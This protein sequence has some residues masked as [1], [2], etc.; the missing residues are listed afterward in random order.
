MNE[1]LTS[2]QLFEL[3]DG[4]S[5][6]NLHREFEAHLA[7]C[8][9]CREALALHARIDAAARALPHASTSATFTARTMNRLPL[10]APM[11]RRALLYRR[12]AQCAAFLA[13]A[14][15]YIWLFVA[16]DVDARGDA[17]SSSAPISTL[18]NNLL[19]GGKQLMTT[20]GGITWLHLL[21]GIAL[22]ALLASLDKAFLS[23]PHHS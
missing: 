21:T 18:G 3:M 22:I 17:A 13:V 20:L 1:H 10:D 14:A 16:G 8:E 15:L 11:N 6:E 7:A 12:L 23:K 4:G 9:Q 2:E 5:H 19:H